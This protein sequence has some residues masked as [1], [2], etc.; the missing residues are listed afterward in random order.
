[1]GPRLWG[2]TRGFIRSVRLISGASLRPAQRPGGCEPSPAARGPPSSCVGPRAA[3]TE[4]FACGHP[5]AKAPERPPGE[6]RAG[7]KPSGEQQGSRPAWTR[8]V[9]ARAVGVAA[10]C[11]LC[12]A[13]R[14]AAGSEVVAGPLESGVRR[15]RWAALPA[16]P[17]RKGS[18]ASPTAVPQPRR[19]GGSP[20]PRGACRPM[21]GQEGGQSC[22]SRTPR[23]RS[24][25]QPGPARRTPE[26]GPRVPFMS[27]ISSVQFLGLDLYEKRQIGIHRTP[28]LRGLP[29]SPHP[30]RLAGGTAVRPQRRGM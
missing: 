24:R 12:R 3:C 23:C 14:A 25:L 18:V 26:R 29:C 27:F 6:P 10:P 7:L 17:L 1:M 4:G 2:K 13:P 5:E 16:A 8:I 21:P 19:A 11:L 9:P 28:P 20:P 22:P 30:Q 15:G